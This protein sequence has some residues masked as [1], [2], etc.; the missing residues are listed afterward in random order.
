MAHLCT[1][2]CGDDGFLKE[3]DVRLLKP[4]FIGD[5]TWLTGRVTA[6]A[7][8]A[9]ADRVELV[10]EGRNQHDELTT[11]ARAVLDLPTD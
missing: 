4:D 6:V 8:A 11:T 3:L 9:G 1:D 5:V 10:L 7:Q 2:W